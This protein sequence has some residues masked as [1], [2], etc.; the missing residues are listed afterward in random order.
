[1]N[2]RLIDSF[3]KSDSRAMVAAALHILAMMADDP[4]Q[5]HRVLGPWAWDLRQRAR[6]LEGAGQTGAASQAKVVARMVSAVALG[7]LSAEALSEAA[8]NVD[9][10][11]DDFRDAL[12][13]LH[14]A[15]KRVVEVVA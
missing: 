3:V 8:A 4:D 10:N 11:A 12:G 7:Q 2:D 15:M 14:S 5:R 9:A 1:M 6:E 13:V